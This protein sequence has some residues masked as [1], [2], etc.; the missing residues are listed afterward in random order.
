MKL[1]EGAIT[2]LSAGVEADYLTILSISGNLDQ[3]SATANGVNTAIAIRQ[4]G[5]FKNQ[6]KVD[7]LVDA[8]ITNYYRM[9][10]NT[11]KLVTKWQSM[12]RNGK[13]KSDL[14]EIVGELE[15]LLERQKSCDKK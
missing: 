9:V 8:Y 15:R 11:T 2:L 10:Q 13:L 14:S 1:N 6:E 5:T 4:A 7:K 12:V 3:L